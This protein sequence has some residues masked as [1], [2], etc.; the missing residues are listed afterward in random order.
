MIKELE[1]YDDDCS[2]DE[3]SLTVHHIIT[4]D[5][6]N[7]GLLCPAIIDNDLI[8]DVDDLYAERD[9]DSED[10]SEYLGNE[11]MPSTLRYHDT[12]SYSLKTISSK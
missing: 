1:V 12:V 6:R 2:E 9:A 7:L 5:G 10:E 8:V 3:E 4:P 11:N